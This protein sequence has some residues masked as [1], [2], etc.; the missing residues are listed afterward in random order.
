MLGFLRRWRE[1]RNVTAFTNGYRLGYQD[2]TAHA[3]QEI[4]DCC[5]DVALLT[6]VIYDLTQENDALRKAG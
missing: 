6:D 5:A 2:A 1:R 3:Q 4:R